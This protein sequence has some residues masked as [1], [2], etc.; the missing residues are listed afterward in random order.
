VLKKLFHKDNLYPLCFVV[1]YALSLNADL[2]PSNKYRFIALALWIGLALFEVMRDRTLFNKDLWDMSRWI[3]LPK[4]IIFAYSVLLFVIGVSNPAYFSTNFTIL[5]PPIGII[6]ILLLFK[7]KSMDYILN[8]F[9]LAFIILF[10]HK[11]TVYGVYECVSI[12]WNNQLTTGVVESFSPFEVHDLTFAIGVLLIYFCFKVFYEKKN[13]TLVEKITCALVIL[14][15]YLG[16]KRIQMLALLLIALYVGVIKIFKLNMSNVNK[17][18]L[19][20]VAFFSVLYLE[21]ILSGGLM[22]VFQFLNIN[23]MGRI[24]YFRFISEICEYTPTFLGIGINNVGKYLM[25]VYSY[26]GV[27]GVH[28]DILKMYAEIGFI[29]FFVWLFYYTCIL[30]IGLGKKFGKKAFTLITLITVYIFILYWTDNVENYYAT[31]FMYLFVPA[32]YCLYGRRNKDGN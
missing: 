24:H 25:D 27:G 19:F 7:E 16:F 1:T 29:M 11:C 31:S 3:I 22:D 32:W 14:F 8:A 26:V 20:S 18:L 23:T 9:I 6:A 28:N 13:L 12:L 15:I 10:F 30:P 17:L 21:G 5:I 2:F 4:I